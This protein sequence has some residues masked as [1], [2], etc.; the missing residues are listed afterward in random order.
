MNPARDIGRSVQAG[1]GLGAG[2]DIW[3]RP[4]GDFPA[5]VAERGEFAVAVRSEPKSMP[6]LGPIGG[7]GKTLVAGGDELHRPI[8]SPGRRRDQYRPRRDRTLRSEG[9]ADERALHVN[10][11]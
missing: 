6:R 3:I 7:D 1:R 10:A 4:R 5:F 11:G 9:A 2:D 8:E